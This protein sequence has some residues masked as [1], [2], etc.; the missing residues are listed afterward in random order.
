M[1]TRP[2]LHQAFSVIAKSQIIDRRY[3]GIRVGS[4]W[5]VLAMCNL[6]I[7]AYRMCVPVER[8]NSLG[9]SCGVAPYGCVP[10]VL[11]QEVRQ[12]VVAS[13]IG[14]PAPWGGIGRSFRRR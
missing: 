7:N 9:R 2:H 3:H 1:A 5:Y 8:T 13:S 14:H 4:F 12:V 6:A 11:V 10:A